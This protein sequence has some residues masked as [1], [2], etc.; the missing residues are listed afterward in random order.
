M[1]FP[2]FAYYRT[3][4]FI[5]LS[6]FSTIGCKT[7]SIDTH[8]S[9]K[10]NTYK[11]HTHIKNIVLDLHGVLF[12]GQTSTFTV[13]KQV[14]LLPFV[15]YGLQFGKEIF[16]VKQMVFKI[17]DKMHPKTTTATRVQDNE[18]EMLPMI[19][20]E[21]LAG[22]KTG[23]ETIQIIKQKAIDQ[24]SLFRSAVEKKLFLKVTELMFA[25]QM[26]AKIQHLN[27]MAYS[28]IK[29]IKKNGFRIYVLSNW[30]KESFD[31]IKTKY[32]DFFKLFNGITISAD[33]GYNKP[34]N[35][36]Y[37]SFFEQHNLNPAECLFIDDQQVNVDGAISCGMNGFV[38]P[39]Q[40]IGFADFQ[41]TYQHI[42]MH[43]K[44][45]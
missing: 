6:L 2:F 14:G 37:Y 41:K 5:C 26:F 33:I 34:A 42:A 20:Q 29:K 25:P 40:K 23:T 7:D 11:P 36:A 10:G 39:Y 3:S 9:I 32:A 1:H 13:I 12:I 27:P 45:N 22:N 8:S 38:C 24:P 15:S 17:L 16:Y 35:E 44:Q 21:W 31:I 43:T 18:A 19:M 4:F 30:D 28:F